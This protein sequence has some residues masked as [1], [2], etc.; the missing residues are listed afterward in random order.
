M[1]VLGR[2]SS[3]S[4]FLM[5]NSGVFASSEALALPTNQKPMANKAIKRLSSRLTET[6]VQQGTGMFKILHVPVR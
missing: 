1:H 5:R 4:Q 3:W 6:A 2:P